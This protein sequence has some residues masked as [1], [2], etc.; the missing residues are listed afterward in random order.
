MGEVCGPVVSLRKACRCYIS[1][2]LESSFPF[3]LGLQ[4]GQVQNSGVNAVSLS[5]DPSSPGSPE[6]LPFLENQ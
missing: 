5:V 6:G 4:L 3:T 2:V 1:G